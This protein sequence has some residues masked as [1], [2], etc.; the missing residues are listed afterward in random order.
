MPY[1]LYECI[2]FVNNIYYLEYDTFKKEC[3]F[4]I[5]IK[6]THSPTQVK[7]GR[8]KF[9]GESRQQFLLTIAKFLYKRRQ[10]IGVNHSVFDLFFH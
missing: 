9:Y 1:K 8:A 5:E 7:V 2:H 4:A 6:F 3:K 10:E